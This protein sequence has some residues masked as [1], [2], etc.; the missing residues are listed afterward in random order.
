MGNRDIGFIHIIGYKKTKY[1]KDYF[2][3]WEI[4]KRNF[5]FKQLKSKTLHYQ[6]I[7][8]HPTNFGYSAASFGT[9][10]TI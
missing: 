8:L 10:C 7:S 2:L 9:E 4:M 6:W 3:N 5:N 1:S